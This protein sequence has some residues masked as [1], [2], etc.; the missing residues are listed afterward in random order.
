MFEW[1]F[2]SR[3]R[4]LTR[5]V[6]Q[7][8]L[9]WNTRV[10]IGLTC[11]R[12]ICATVKHEVKFMFNRFQLEMRQKSWVRDFHCF[13]KTENIELTE[14]RRVKK[15][16]DCCCIHLKGQ[17]TQTAVSSHADSFGFYMPTLLQLA[18]YKGGEW[19]YTLALQE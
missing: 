13:C 4:S 7:K 12:F 19:N 5:E 2:E 11:W 10:T 6:G 14:R 1:R 8:G 15:W 9:S 17:F 16:G 18:W 3:L